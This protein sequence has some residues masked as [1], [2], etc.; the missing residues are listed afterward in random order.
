VPRWGALAL[1][2]LAVGLAVATLPAGI[3]GA[4]LP[5]PARATGGALDR[6]SA[7]A[8]PPRLR[9]VAQGAYVVGDEHVL[10][11]RL[12]H[13]EGGPAYQPR[14]RAIYHRGDASLAVAVGYAPLRMLRAGETTFVVVR[15]VVPIGW[16]SY[17]VDAVHMFTSTV[18]RYT[19]D[20]LVLT[21]VRSERDGSTVRV[22]GRVTNTTPERLIGVR[23]PIGLFDASGTLVDAA[24]ATPFGD[25]PAQP[26]QAAVFN[27][28]FPDPIGRLPTDHTV[29]AQAEGYAG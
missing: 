25:Q 3:G 13:E 14:V 22:T 17:E 12:T 8:A 27:Q 21:G 23:V 9:A 2:G 6:A 4:L 7:R 10:L 18:R 16:D 26:G 19:H 5:S 1:T 28:G 24:Y 20:G 15:S 11:A 29:V